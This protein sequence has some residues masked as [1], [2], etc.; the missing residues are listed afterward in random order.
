MY[1]TQQSAVASCQW[2]EGSVLV[3]LQ[4]VDVVKTTADI[5]PA[6]PLGAV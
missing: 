6:F 3:P 4:L 2:E 5:Q 1:V